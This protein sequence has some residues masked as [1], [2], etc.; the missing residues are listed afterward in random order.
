MYSLSSTFKTEKNKASNQPIYLYTIHDYN[1]KNIP[2]V[3]PGF[4]DW[5]DGISSTPDG[6]NIAGA[7][8][9]T[10]RESSIKKRGSFSAKFTSAGTDANLQQTVHADK[11][12]EYWRGKTVTFG[13]WVY[14]TVANTARIVIQDGDAVNELSAFHSGN[15]TWEWLEVTATIGAGATL[16]NLDCYIA[17]ASSFAYFDGLVCVEGDSVE[18]INLNFAEYDTDIV[19]DGITYTKFPIRHEEIG[20]NSQG[21]IDSIRVSVSNINRVI[22]AYLEDYD[23]RGKKVTITLVWA[24]QLADTDANLQFIFYIDSYTASQEIVEFTLSSKYDI[25]DL[26]LPNG[27]YNRNYCRWKFKSTE[28][29]YAGAQVTC[30][31][32]KTTCKVLMENISRFGG[33]PSVPTNRIFT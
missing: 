32:R 27:I 30:D 9:S 2:I 23:L 28:C 18:S 20:E 15:S 4:E 3:N 17:L 24:N 10:D 13:C 22:Q 33:F 21:E 5:N 11:G 7:G 14:A 19:Y 1:S 16:V 25:I 31:K 26:A 8:A 12:I 6:Y 29:A